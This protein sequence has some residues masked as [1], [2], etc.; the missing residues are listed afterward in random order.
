M[1]SMIMRFR[2]IGRDDIGN[3]DLVAAGVCA[4]GE[5]LVKGKIYNVPDNEDIAIQG[6]LLSPYFIVID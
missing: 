1:E 2:Y 6:C 5:T 3:M 4:R